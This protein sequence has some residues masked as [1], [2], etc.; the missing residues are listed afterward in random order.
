MG[1]A[2]IKLDG[3]NTVKG[4]LIAV[5][6][7]GYYA[8]IAVPADKTLTIEGS[9]SLIASSGGNNKYACGIGGGIKKE[10][11]ETK[12]INSGNIIINGGTVTATGGMQ[13]A[14]I[15][16][17]EY[18][19]CGTI[20]IN[21]GTVTATGGNYGAGIG[22]GYGGFCAGITINGGEINAT[23]ANAAGV[24]SGY[25]GALCGDITITGGNVTANGGNNAAGIGTGYVGNGG[26]IV[27][28]STVTQVTATK[29][30]SAVFSIGRGVDGS[31][32]TVTI[33][34]STKVIEQ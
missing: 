11:G 21:G 34:D 15:G 29:G 19:E 1:D 18:S 14:G 23:G 33:G 9:G 17:A 13:A 24:G 26:D 3:S 25:Y 5:T 32:G 27:I 2:T 22:T 6:G 16:G 4:G 30:F 7:F 31:C 28:E 12:G 10:N 8:G 20:T